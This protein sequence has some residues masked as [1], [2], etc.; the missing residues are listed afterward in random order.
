[1]EKECK[2]LPQADSDLLKAAFNEVL[3]DYIAEAG[4]L[5]EKISLV[6]EGHSQ[7]A[8]SK[9]LVSISVFEIP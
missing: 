9:Q 1:M 5:P 8:A 7:S 2:N 6:A 3:S 4:V